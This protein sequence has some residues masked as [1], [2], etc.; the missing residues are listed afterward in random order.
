MYFLLLLIVNDKVVLNVWNYSTIPFTFFWKQCN[1]FLHAWVFIN[2]SAFGQVDLFMS[3]FG[4]T[5][6]SKWYTIAMVPDGFK[7]TTYRKVK[8]HVVNNDAHLHL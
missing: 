2:R 8:N 4:I 7:P 5:V 1:L 3:V 6:Q